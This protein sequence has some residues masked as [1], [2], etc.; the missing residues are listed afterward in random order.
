MPE[1]HD[2]K[3]SMRV[4][5]E[6]I[7]VNPVTKELDAS[8]LFSKECYETWLSTRRKKVPNPPKHFQRTISAHLTGLDGRVPFYEAEERA[9][10]IEARK[11]QIWP[12]FEDFPDPKPQVGMLGFRALGYH[13]KRAQQ[14]QDTKR[15]RLVE[16]PK[17]NV[18]I[19]ES[20]CASSDKDE[21]L[22]RGTL[23]EASLKSTLVPKMMSMAEQLPGG[24]DPFAG[25]FDVSR[26]L[27]YGQTNALSFSNRGDVEY[28]KRLLNEEMTKPGRGVDSNTFIIISDPTAK[29]AERRVVAQNPLAITLFGLKQGDSPSNFRAEELMWLVLALGSSFSNPGSEFGVN[30]HLKGAGGEEALY[31]ATFCVDPNSFLLVRTGRVKH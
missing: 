24:G 14:M 3:T 10:L 28:A 30:M 12:C 1:E 15:S 9:V 21:E 7:H 29:D 16:E 13:E 4:F 19:V 27:L 2:S 31:E 6:F 5:R 18:P 26:Y 23:L 25:L 22:E 17:S 8:P 11:K 20:F